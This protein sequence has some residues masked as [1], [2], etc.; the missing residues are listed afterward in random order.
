MKP[1]AAGILGFSV[2]LKSWVEGK[3]LQVKMRPVR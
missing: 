2:E 3:Q 1:L